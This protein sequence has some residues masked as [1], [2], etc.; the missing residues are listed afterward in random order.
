MAREG[1]PPGWVPPVYTR[2]DGEP[3]QVLIT[4]E[5]VL[6]RLNASEH[7]IRGPGRRPPP[8]YDP[9]KEE[10]CEHPRV[11]SFTAKPDDRCGGKWHDGAD[12]YGPIPRL[13]GLSGGDGYIGA[14]ICVDCHRIL[15]LLTEEILAAA[16]A[17]REG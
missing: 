10:V 11:F 7:G 8:K 14:R 9:P 6:E 17:N 12:W 1:K 2:T 13:S 5:A 4:D 15:G 3:F 16:V